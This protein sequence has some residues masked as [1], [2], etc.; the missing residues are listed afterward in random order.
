MRYRR[1]DSS[2]DY[3]FGAGDNTF[4]VNTPDAVAQAVKTRFALWQGEWFLDTTAGTP[5]KTD[6]L[7]KHKSLVYQMAVRERIL[8]TQGVSEITEFQ[9]QANPQTRRVTFTSTINTLFGTTT[10]NSEA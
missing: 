4:M 8:D 7:G 6:I 9:V 1:E 2:G 5:Y 3:I 10:I